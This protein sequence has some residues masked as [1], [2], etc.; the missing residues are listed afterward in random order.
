MKI[1]IVIFVPGKI[2]LIYYSVKIRLTRSRFP[3]ARG[4]ARKTTRE[5]K[6]WGRGLLGVYRSESSRVPVVPYFFYFSFFTLPS[7]NL[8]SGRD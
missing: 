2:G 4:S 3:V 6:I 5:E 8:T 7:T 1:D